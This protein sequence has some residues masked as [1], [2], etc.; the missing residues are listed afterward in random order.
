MQAYADEVRQ[1]E[2]YFHGLGM[3][4]IP[5]SRNNIADELSKIAARKEKVPPGVFLERLLKPSVDPQRPKI[6]KRKI[7]TKVQFLGEPPSL[8]PSKHQVLTVSHALLGW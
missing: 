5:R 8:I 2:K 7:E 3:E 6:K 4:H 1:L